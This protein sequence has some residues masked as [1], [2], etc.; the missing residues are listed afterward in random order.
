MKVYTGIEYKWDDDSNALVE[1]SSESYDYEGRI[2]M[3]QP[4]NGP[5]DD[6]FGFDPGDVTEGQ[7]GMDA[8]AGTYNYWL[9]LLPPDV[10]NEMMGIFSDVGNVG[11]Y[12]AQATVPQL[13]AGGDVSG[14]W[15][16][17]DAFNPFAGVPGMEW[18]N[19]YSAVGPVGG[20]GEDDAESQFDAWA[21]ST[22]YEGTYEDAFGAGAGLAQEW[23]EWAE[24]GAGGDI[25]SPY[26]LYNY[27][28]GQPQFYGEI[29]QP[30]SWGFPTVAWNFLPYIDI[31]SG[32]SVAQGLG[33]A[34]DLG[35][36]LPSQTAL[37]PDLIKRL[38]GSYYRPYVEAG[39][40]ELSSEIRPQIEAAQ[41]QIGKGIDVYGGRARAEESLWNQFGAGMGGI[42]ANVE[43]QR[44]EAR[45]AIGDIMGQWRQALEQA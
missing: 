4:P 27:M 3:A 31:M 19:P 1:I 12:G 6:M 34:G 17:S 28:M 38:R 45:G 26:H 29:N 35:T 21:A 37:T 13:I 14:Q 7:F 42:F 18:Y 2:A 41:T 23:A 22:G 8:T 16:G 10:L 20:W 25:S 32:E 5:E 9:N 15:G 39:R 43:G 40:E 11:G 36:A 33:E 44:G 24:S 30:S